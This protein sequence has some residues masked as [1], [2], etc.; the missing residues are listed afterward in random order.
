MVKSILKVQ[1][2]KYNQVYLLASLTSGLV[3]Y[4]STLPIHLTDDLLSEV[5]QILHDNQFAKQQRVLGLVKLLGELYNDLVVDS[6]I[7]FDMLYTFISTGNER[8]GAMADA[9]SD[10]LRVR[11]V[12]TLLD[13]CGHYFDRGSTKKKLDTFIAHFQV[14]PLLPLLSFTHYTHTHTHMHTH[15]RAFTDTQT[16]GPDDKLAVGWA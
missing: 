16:R 14:S 12:C 4:H 3:R 11:L 7:I 1:K 8:V 6:P 9:P 15:T 5:R 10:F 13:T 2:I